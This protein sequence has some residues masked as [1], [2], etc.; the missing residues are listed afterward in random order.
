MHAKRPPDVH[1]DIV[2][3][4]HEAMAG[5]LVERPVNLDIVAA[6]DDVA[7]VVRG[8]DLGAVELAGALGSACGELEH[9]LGAQL[10]RMQPFDAIG[11]REGSIVGKLLGLRRVEK[12]K[13][14]RPGGDVDAELIGRTEFLGVCAEA[15]LVLVGVAGEKIVILAVAGHVPPV[16]ARERVVPGRLAAVARFEGEPIV[17]RTRLRLRRCRARRGLT[18]GARPGRSPWSRHDGC[19]RSARCGRGAGIAPASEIA[20]FDGTLCSPTRCVC[21]RPPSPPCLI[22]RP[23]SSGC[24]CVAD[25]PAQGNRPRVIGNHPTEG[26]HPNQS[27]TRTLVRKPSDWR[28]Q[29][30]DGW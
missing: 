8:A 29:P 19:Q 22:R 13:Q 30:C 5:V 12:P 7:V 3:D 17:T 15:E 20:P 16:A 14:R 10:E 11:R 28:S 23:G 21:P 6:R 18:R 2:G 4:D 27:Q 26:E 1:L 9:R 25:S 24:K